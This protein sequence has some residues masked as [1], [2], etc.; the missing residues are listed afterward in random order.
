MHDMITDGVD[1]M[2]PDGSDL[3]RLALYLS[4]VHPNLSDWADDVAVLIRSYVAGENVLDTHRA[5]VDEVWRFVA[6]ERDALSGVGL[7]AYSDLLDTVAALYPY[8]EEIY[9]LMGNNGPRHYLF[10][11]QNTGESRPNGGFF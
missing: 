4:P 1:V 6:Q 2:D 7:A 3:E 11:L 8:R 5:R 10:V 9:D